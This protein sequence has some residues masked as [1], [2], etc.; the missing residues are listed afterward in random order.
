MST[1]HAPGF[2][3]FMLVMIPVASFPQEDRSHF[4]EVFNREKPYRIFLPDDYETSGKSYPVIYYFHGNK[5][6]HVSSLSDVMAAFVKENPVIVVAW[7][8]RSADS[9]V[10]PYN[11][12]YHSNINY[13]TQ[14]KDYFLEFVAHIDSNYRTLTDRANRA[15]I[16][17]SM[18]GIMS[19]FIAGKY[20]HMVGTA[21]NSK[22]SPEF[23]IGYPDNHTLYPV[24]YMF[25]NLHGVNLRFHN[26]TTGEL[27][28]LNDEVHAGALQEGGLAYEYQVYEGG[29]SLMPGDLNDALDFVLR[30]FKNPL[31]AP[32]RWHHADL[33]PG[34]GVWGY[35]V[36]SNLGEPGFIEMRGVTKGGMW[37]GT[38]KWQP[39]GWFIPG[40][41]INVTTPP[42]YEPNTD[43]TLMDYNVT[44]DSRK[45]LHHE[46]NAEGC[47]AFSVNHEEHQIGL[48]KKNDP[49]EIVCLAHKV[50]ERNIFLTHHEP[51]SLK[52]RL[53]NRGGSEAKNVKVE[54]SCSDPDVSIANP[55]IEA[56]KLVPGE[57]VWIDPEFRIIASNKPPSN[58]APFRLKFHLLMTDGKN[59]WRDEFEAPVIYDVPE[60]TNIGIDDGDSEIFGSGNGNNI[61]EPGESVMIYEVSHRT[62]LYY[63]DPCIDGERIH[64]DLQPDKWGDGYAVSSVIHVSEG[65]PIGHQI[66]FLASYEVKEWKTIKR[67]V[68]W[69]T[70]TITV[71]KPE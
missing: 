20:P 28:Y 27:V 33:Y 55:M 46:S 49:P 24:R 34:F 59:T 15:I 56:G 70:F 69:G 25:G 6:S 10:R 7:N 40:V 66:R 43:Y 39:D 12:G 9:D 8:G 11:I 61:T 37:I 68:T 48:W 38:K 31:P 58:G 64:V 60:F 4:S 52:L 54:I 47:I 67:N 44:Q 51:C 42:V 62:R 21:V 13:E 22:G 50:D 18:G 71:G 65:C 41:Q 23:F 5:G 53:L 19:F 57:P 1:R 26:S 45:I 32:Q 29:H 36:E 30:S 16:G 3:L 17:H 63:D 2:L 35:R 14:F